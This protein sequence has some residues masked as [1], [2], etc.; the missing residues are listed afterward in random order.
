MSTDFLRDVFREKA[1]AEAMIWCG[2]S[3]DY[4][5]LNDR[6]TYWVDRLTNEGVGP[7]DVTMLQGDF[8]P[9]SVALLLALLEK[10][11]ICVPLNAERV[12]ER[13]LLVETA[14][15]RWIIAVDDKDSVAIS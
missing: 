12:T 11:C 9:N 3:Y 14:R 13:A 5:W 7:G 4:A 15:I 10:N 8:S 6:I 1:L 2:Q